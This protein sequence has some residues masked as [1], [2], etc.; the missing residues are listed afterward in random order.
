MSCDIGHRRSSD[1]TLLW[2]WLRPVAIA[3]I[4]PLVWEVAYA[5]GWGPKKMKERGKKERKEGRKEER[6]R[7]RERERR[8]GRKEG[9][10]K[11]KRGRNSLRF[12][13]ALDSPWPSLSHQ[14]RQLRAVL[15]LGNL[16]VDEAI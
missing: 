6:E 4:Q 10:K 12:S 7:E 5:F 13:A 3:P 11:K 8:E 15:G 14:S 16:R 9:R 2:L 1:P